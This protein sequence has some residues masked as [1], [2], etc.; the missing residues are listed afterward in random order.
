MKHDMQRPVVVGLLFTAIIGCGSGTTPPP[1]R[2]SEAPKLAAAPVSVATEGK[3]PK[4]EPPSA[5]V[6]PRDAWVAKAGTKFADM[7]C[8]PD[9]LFAVCMP[10]LFPT[11]KADYLEAARVCGE[12]FRPE[13][14]AVM[15]AEA[16]GDWDMRLSMCMSTR[17]GQA[18]VERDPGAM[19]EVP[20]AQ[21]DALKKKAEEARADG[22]AVKIPAVK[23]LALLEDGL[24]RQMCAVSSSMCHE[25]VDACLVR[26]K[27]LLTACEKKQRLAK[28]K[29][30][31]DATV[32]KVS[33][34]IATCVTE[35]Y[36]AAPGCK[37]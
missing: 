10:K 14:P 8:S 12:E 23:F 33:L 7:M 32:K 26:F 9:N 34:A 18:L 19:V 31:D 21:C 37:S 35:A 5:E 20:S 25:T 27:P 2:E 28:R 24:P 30:L 16:E 4:A 36:M 3:A 15:T 29:E 11:C 22:V 13:I 17:Y 6:D 1:K